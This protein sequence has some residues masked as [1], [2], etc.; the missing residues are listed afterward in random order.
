MAGGHAR[1]RF[2]VKA[3]TGVAAA[4]AAASRAAAAGA[5]ARRLAS[6]PPMRRSGV[7][8]WQ[9]YAA[10][11]L[12]TALS[13]LQVSHSRRRPY[14]ICDAALCFV[15]WPA[16]ICHAAPSPSAFGAYISLV[17]NFDPRI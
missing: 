8:L 17:L 3:P 2:V 10:C 12:G 5:A 7:S 1:S 6:P 16:V 13:E 11:G 14:T 9:L 4:T 15:A